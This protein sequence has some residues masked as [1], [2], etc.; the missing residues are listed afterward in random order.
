MYEHNHVL[1][2]IVPGTNHRYCLF[3]EATFP[4][5]GTYEIREFDGNLER[6][7]ST[8]FA[9]RDGHQIRRFL[10]LSRRDI[11][12]HNWH[13]NGVYVFRVTR[14]PITCEELGT[15]CSAD[16]AACDNAP[17]RTAACR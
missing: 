15:S 11:L 13:D 9:Q 10:G 2:A 12:L 1:G 17:H 4:A 7:P 16:G 14:C 6:Y 8:L 5:D 3:C